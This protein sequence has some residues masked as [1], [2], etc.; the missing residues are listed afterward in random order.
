MKVRRVVTITGM[1]DIFPV[2]GSGGTASCADPNG[3]RLM[4]DLGTVYP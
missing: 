3:F 4:A 2:T 1:K